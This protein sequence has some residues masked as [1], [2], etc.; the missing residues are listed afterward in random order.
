MVFLIL[1]N[2]AFYKKAKKLRKQRSKKLKKERAKKAEPSRRILE[3]N[4]RWG[5]TCTN[6]ADKAEETSEELPNL[7][8]TSRRQV[9]FLDYDTVY[10]F[11]NKE[12]RCNI[13]YKIGKRKRKLAKSKM[14]RSINYKN[15]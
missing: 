2:T 10:E 8:K 15:A 1:Q 7:P 3:V 4:E 9:S 5:I 13:F 11:P 14:Y 12:D 6:E